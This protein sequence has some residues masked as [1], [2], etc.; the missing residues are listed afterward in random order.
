FDDRPSE[1]FKARWIQ[2][3]DGAIIPRLKRFARSVGHLDYAIANSKTFRQRKQL[4]S[5][6]VTDK[7]KTRAP[8]FFAARE[9]PKRAVSIFSAQIG[10]DVQ[11]KRKIL[12]ESWNVFQARGNFCFGQFT[13]RII[14]AD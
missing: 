8:L 13:K 10:A 4:R 5:E 7:N 3:R 1:T 12:A 11:N 6:C 2:Q 9:N 14:R